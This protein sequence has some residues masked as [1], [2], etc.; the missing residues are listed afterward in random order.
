[1]S[2]KPKKPKL[3]QGVGKAF[4]RQGWKEVGQ[5]VE[6]F[7]TGSTLVSEAG[8]LGTATTQAVSQQTG[9]SQ[10]VKFDNQL[11]PQGFEAMNQSSPETPVVET[12]DIEAPIQEPFLENLVEQVQEMAQEP[13]M[14]MEVEQ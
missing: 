11:S 14:E 9:V 2:E 3:G 4:V 1:M 13:E 7:P 8:Q 6:A 5:L 10:P 12:P